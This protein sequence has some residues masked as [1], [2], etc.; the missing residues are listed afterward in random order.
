MGHIWIGQVLQCFGSTCNLQNWRISAANINYL[1]ESMSIQCFEG[2]LHSWKRK[3]IPLFITLPPSFFVVLSYALCRLLALQHGGVWRM[4][5]VIFFS[6][7]NLALASLRMHL[8]F[9]PPYPWQCF[10]GKVHSMKRKCIIFFSSLPPS[11]FIVV[12]CALCWL[13]A[14]Q[15]RGVWRMGNIHFLFHYQFSLG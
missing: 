8:F 4:G 15:L 12:S 9:K 3:C 7:F 6:I 10:D 13:L 2:E 11:L 14:L 5:D 1:Q